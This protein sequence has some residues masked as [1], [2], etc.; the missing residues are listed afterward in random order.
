MKTKEA[1]DVLVS[2]FEKAEDE[3][4][5]SDLIFS[6]CYL[7]SHYAI[8]LGMPLLPGKYDN[9]FDSLEKNL[10]IVATLNGIEHPQLEEWRKIA[11]EEGKRF[12]NTL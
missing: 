5:K 6:L 9:T 3:Y 2:L 10:Y 11:Q 4:I 1:E 12:R 8:V 7:A